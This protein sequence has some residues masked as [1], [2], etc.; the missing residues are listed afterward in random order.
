MKKDF[1]L[2]LLY[3]IVRRMVMLENKRQI[4]TKYKLYF[5]VLFFLII[6]SIGFFSAQKEEPITEE[7]LFIEKKEEFK[8]E[9]KIKIDI[10]GAVVTPGVYL[11]KKE[12]RVEDAI[13]ES[14]GLREDAD[15]NYINLSKKVKDEMVIIIYTKEEIGKMVEGNQTIKYIDKECICPVKQNDACLD[16]NKITNQKEEKK[17]TG[18]ININ[19]A[20]LDILQTLTGIGEAKAKLIIKYREQTPFTQIEEI[21][22]VKG[23]GDSIF[24]K[25]KNHITV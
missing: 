18:P 14:G 6:L 11:L 8:S 16:S 12:A 2:F 19:T 3:I 13:K 4:F 7:T 17:E 10:K 5:I 21:K 1:L 24:E 20:S 23:I 25:I 22:N 9:K 15:T